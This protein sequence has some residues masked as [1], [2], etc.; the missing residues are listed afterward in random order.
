MQR[1]HRLTG[2]ESFSNIRKYGRGVANQFLVLRIHPNGLDTSR[3][4]FL[5]GKRIGNAVIRN[6][7]KRRLREA[8]R[9]SDVKT[10]WDAIFIARRGSGTA[11]YRQLEE[12]VVNLLSR[13]N[14]LEDRAHHSSLP[15][16]LNSNPAEGM[17][18]PLSPTSGAVQH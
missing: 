11:D 3:Y 6:R 9:A 18:Q 14:L 15:S 1:E 13:T 8:V 5:T 2:Q 4:A 17:T 7:M 10:G 12:S 16:S